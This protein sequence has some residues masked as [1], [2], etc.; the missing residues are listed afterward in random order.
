MATAGQN[1]EATRKS[2]NAAAKKQPSRQGACGTP[3]VYNR[4]E[5]LSERRKMMQAWADYLQALEYKAKRVS[6]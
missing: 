2:R 3:Q 6:F 5:Y 4:A 1:A